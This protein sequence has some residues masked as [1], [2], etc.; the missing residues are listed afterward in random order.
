M[1]FHW[2]L[3]LHYDSRVHK[4][5]QNLVKFIALINAPLHYV[6]LFQICI[7]ASLVNTKN[8]YKISWILKK[9]FLQSVTLF[10]QPV[11]VWVAMTNGTTM[12]VF[13]KLFTNVMCNDF[14]SF[15]EHV[16]DERQGKCTE[17]KLFGTD[18]RLFFWSNINFSHENFHP[19]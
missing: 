2:C 17:A 10:S 6:T 13:L 14:F 5:I 18:E 7:N 1:L 16:K 15:L 19:T 8:K 9:V 11:L 3:F 12:L 4:G